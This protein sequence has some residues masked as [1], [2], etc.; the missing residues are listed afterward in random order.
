MLEADA[1]LGPRKTT[2]DLLHCIKT[3][4]LAS[5]LKEFP[6]WVIEE[7]K[8]GEEIFDDFS[9]SEMIQ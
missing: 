1:N 6:E 4:T 3:V 7:E 2:E 8:R 9:P 5:C